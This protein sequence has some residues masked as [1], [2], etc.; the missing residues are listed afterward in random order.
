MT[1]ETDGITY[2]TGAS[3]T[4]A[5]MPST[6]ATRLTLEFQ[7]GKLYFLYMR[8]PHTGEHIMPCT[9]EC[10]RQWWEMMM[11]HYFTTLDVFPPKRDT[12]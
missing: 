11:I 6:T 2:D 7:E 9:R 1:R 3:V 12:P 5:E 10:A 8:S 4:V